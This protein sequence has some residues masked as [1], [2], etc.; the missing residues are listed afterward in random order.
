M[1]RYAPSIQQL[2][3]HFTKLPGIG[4]KTAERLVFSLLRKRPEDVSAFSQ[5]LSLLHQRTVVCGRCFTYSETNPCNICGNPKRTPTQVCVVARPQDLHA[6]EKT[7]GFD[8]LYH[9]LGGTIDPL[10]GMVADQLT[11]PQL[12]AR[13]APDGVQEVILAL[14]PDISGETTML[15]LTK[16]LKPTGVAISRLARGLPT[17]SDVEY[18]DETTLTNALQA[19]Q[20]L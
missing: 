1:A 14:N 11:I 5:S 6:I 13:I 12:I 17:G 8:G 3:E 10:E 9:V 18:A 15:Y 20:K 4:P 19:R 16:L 2:I 7:A